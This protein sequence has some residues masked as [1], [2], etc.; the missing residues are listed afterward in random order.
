MR[1]AV[2][3]SDVHASRKSWFLTAGLCLVS[4]TAS[5]HTRTVE[6]LPRRLV[7]APGA[8]DGG[9]SVV[10]GRL[11]EEVWQLAEPATDFIQQDPQNGSPATERTDVRILYTKTALYMG[12][13]CFDSEPDRLLRFQR[14]RDEFLQAD[15]RFQWV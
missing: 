14:R 10:D 3:M 4:C 8:P 9:K 7:P 12:V 13:T 2:R 11:D 6:A 5:A 15:D 1:Y